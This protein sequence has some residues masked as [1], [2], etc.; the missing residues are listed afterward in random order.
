MTQKL[1]AQ[2]RNAMISEVYAKALK[3]CGY[4]AMYFL[5][6]VEEDGGLETA[7]RLLHDQ[8]LS[9][10]FT[11]LYDRHRLDL[12]MEALILQPKW[13]PLFSDEELSIASKKLKD[14]GYDGV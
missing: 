9:Y 4:P 10:G 3:E 13:R 12:T 7:K 2:F 6:M 1:K 8:S 5:R 11:F 14:C